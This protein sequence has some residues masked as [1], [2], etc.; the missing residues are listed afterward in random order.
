M[1]KSAGQGIW[2]MYA[3]FGAT[4]LILAFGSKVWP[5]LVVNT[6]AILL[7]FL[8]GIMGLG[9]IATLLMPLFR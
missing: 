7:M 9:L 2:Q 6:G 8:F 3:L 4:V 5:N 1:F